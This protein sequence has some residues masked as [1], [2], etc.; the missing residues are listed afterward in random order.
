MN[1]QGQLVV[2]GCVPHKVKDVVTA[3]AILSA[4]LPVDPP[5]PAVMEETHPDRVKAIVTTMDV[6]P[7]DLPV[8]PPAPKLMTTALPTTS[9]LRPWVGHY[10]PAPAVMEETHP[11]RVKA[12]VTTMAVLPEDPPAPKPMTT[13]LPTTSVLRPWVGH[14]VPAPTVM[15]KEEKP[16]LEAAPEAPPTQSNMASEEEMDTSVQPAQSRGQK[17]KV[18]LS[19][20]WT[21][22]VHLHGI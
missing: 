17:G 14:C 11:D 6:L 22:D 20:A 13:A 9:V 1:N 16:A 2:F 15:S 3:M 19:R 18:K 10:V 12:I 7:E 5:A 4:G 21:V 8:D